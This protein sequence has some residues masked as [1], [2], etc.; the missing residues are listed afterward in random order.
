MRSLFLSVVLGLSALGLTLGPLASSADAQWGWRRGWYSS[1]YYPTYTYSYPAYS[2]YYPGYSSYY[3]P[4][5][6]YGVPS[7]YSTWS[8]PYYGSYYYTPSYSSYY[9]T[10][11]YSYPS[12]SYGYYIP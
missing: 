3:T 4:G 12:Y 11:V 5:Y 1:Y 6:T 10:P 8:T 2:Y 7:Y 9:S